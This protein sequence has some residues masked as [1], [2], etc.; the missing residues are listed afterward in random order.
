[1]R[2]FTYLTLA[3]LA[4]LS[5]AA[6][7]KPLTRRQDPGSQGTITAINT[8][9]ADVDQVN[10]FL[11]LVALNP[12]LSTADLVANAQIA[13][14]RAQDEPVELGILSQVPS[15]SAAG[16]DGVS[17]LQGVFVNVI[18]SL[19]N[20]INDPT[21]DVAGNVGVINEVRCC[22]VLPSVD[23]LWPAAAAAEG[24]TDQVISLKA[25]RPDACSNGVILCGGNPPPTRV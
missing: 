4:G 19:N 8:W 5:A 20:I 3:T 22:F 17:T 6:P 1:M 7:S 11:N 21:G 18:N 16:Q 14:A 23:E 15:L 2:S 9:V 25:G 12:Q 24:V 10:G 13:L